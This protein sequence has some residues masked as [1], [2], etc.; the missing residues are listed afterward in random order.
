VGDLSSTAT[1]AAMPAR[2][3]VTVY[4]CIERSI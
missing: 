2:I 3:P 1:S 4:A